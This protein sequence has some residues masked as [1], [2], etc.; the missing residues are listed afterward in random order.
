MKSGSAHPNRSTEEQL[1]ILSGAEPF[2]FRAGRTGCLL[3]HGFTGTPFEMRGLGE[4][5]A[6]AGLTAL[7]PRLFAHATRQ[8][9]LTRARWQDW[10]ASA[11]DGYHLLSGCCD[12]IIPIGLSMGGVLALLLASASPVAGAVTLSTPLHPPDRRMR[13][14]RPVAPIVSKLRRF[15]DKGPADF[16]DPA[17]ASTHLEYP[18]Y[19]IRA[20]AE[21]YDLILEMRKHLVEVRCPVLVVHSRRDRSV[22]FSDG[23]ALMAK[24]GSQ[25]KQSL[26][27]EH[28][29]H[30]VTRDT[31]LRAVFEA[32]AA[33]VQRLARSTR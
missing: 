15:A 7:G 33:F 22:R 4:H 16:D 12:A 31:E 13:P 27:L 26:W 17:A 9:D 21:L 29:G 32:V 25:D 2:F 8:E 14:L 5:L 18:Q 10:L 28:S 30:V 3:L 20:A 24:L 23:E 6:G 1:A 11:E 19:P